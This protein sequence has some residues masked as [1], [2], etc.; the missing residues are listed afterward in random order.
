MACRRSRTMVA[1][2]IGCAVT[3]MLA[4]LAAT[5]HLSAKLTGL[6]DSSEV[7]RIKLES[8]SRW[9]RIIFRRISKIERSVG[10]EIS[11]D[12]IP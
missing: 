6:S 1:A 9:L 11:M 2:I 5:W 7:A 4:L 8:H 10:I 3:I 12:D